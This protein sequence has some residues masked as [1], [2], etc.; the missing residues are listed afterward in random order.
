MMLWA[1]RRHAGG[2]PIRWPR[3]NLPS[4]ALPVVISGLTR[5]DIGGLLLGRGRVAGPPLLWEVHTLASAYG[6]CEAEILALSAV[7]GAGYLDMVQS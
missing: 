4:I 3:C 2:W 1:S 5:F 6:W 7:R